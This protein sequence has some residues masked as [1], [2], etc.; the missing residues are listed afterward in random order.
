MVKLSTKILE[1]DNKE[2]DRE[3]TE[4]SIQGIDSEDMIS[5]ILREV[6][7][8]EHIHD[9]TSDRVLLW[10]QRKEAESAKGGFRQYK[11]GQGL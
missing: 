8:L 6:S 1:C 5:E 2:Y 7:A 11:G 9:V 4:Q 10:A 3:L